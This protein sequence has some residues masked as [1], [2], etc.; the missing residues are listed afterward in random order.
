M[1]ATSQISAS[2]KPP[3]IH[4]PGLPADELDGSTLFFLMRWKNSTSFLV[5]WGFHFLFLI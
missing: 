5:I 4:S 3:Q 1:M 2:G